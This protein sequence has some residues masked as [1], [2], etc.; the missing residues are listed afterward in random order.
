MKAVRATRSDGRVQGGHCVVS[1]VACLIGLCC[2]VVTRGDETPQG[3]LA[4]GEILKGTIPERNRD[5]ALI[6]QL[7]LL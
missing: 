1:V 2:L 4:P 7:R 6:W 3:V 5:G